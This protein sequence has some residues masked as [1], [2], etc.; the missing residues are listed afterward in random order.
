[1]VV[2]KVASKDKKE[3][4][5]NLVTDAVVEIEVVTDAVVAVEIEE[6]AVAR[7]ADLVVVDKVDQEDNLKIKNLKFRINNVTAKKI[8]AQEDA[9][10]SHERR[11]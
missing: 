4:D 8:K 6:A 9:E 7:V 5:L 2:K 11:Y 10:R 1:V 3:E